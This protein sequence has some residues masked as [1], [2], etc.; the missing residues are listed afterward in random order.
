MEEKQTNQPVPDAPGLC[1]TP[2]PPTVVFW[3]KLYCGLMAFVYLA[4]FVVGVLLAVFHQSIDTKEP[5]EMLMPGIIYGALGFFFSIPF[6]AAFFLPRRSWAWIY[7]LVL[8]CIGLTSCCCLPITIP[9]LI[10]WI[11]PEVKTYFK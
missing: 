10:Y 5:G 2:E 4:L 9:L 6:V 1:V 11:K 8:I 3:Y 7:H